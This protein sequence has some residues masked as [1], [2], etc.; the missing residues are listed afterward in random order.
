MTPVS[1]IGRLPMSRLPAAYRGTAHPFLV[2]G[3]KPPD[4]SMSRVFLFCILL[5]LSFNLYMYMYM[6]PSLRGFKGTFASWW[7][8][9][10]RFQEGMPLQTFDLYLC[11]LSKRWVRFSSLLRFMD[12]LSSLSAMTDQYH[13]IVLDCS[14]LSWNRYSRKSA[15]DF[16][17]GALTSTWF[18][19]PGH[20]G[21]S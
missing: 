6:Y 12:E 21:P 20:V 19:K 5:L 17:G 14:F 7:S 2:P 8:T 1:P 4:G 13:S 9:R 3:N 18:P 15:M 16:I 11:K 10:E